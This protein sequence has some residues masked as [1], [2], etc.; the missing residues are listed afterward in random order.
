[1]GEGI[2]TALIC[3]VMSPAAGRSVVS[4][5]T[6]SQSQAALARVPTY[7]VCSPLSN[8][9]RLPLIA[10]RC[11]LS[12][13]RTNGSPAGFYQMTTDERFDRIEEL[14]R[15]LIE[16]RKVK[17]W[18][19]VNEVAE[20]LGKAPFTIREHARLGRISASKRKSGRGPHSE[21]MVSHEEL[22]RIQ[23]EGLLPDPRVLVSVPKTTRWRR[24][25]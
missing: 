12:N 14:L 1:M 13:E 22:I 21:W 8:Y 3:F 4:Q 16:Q 5:T 7:L 17:D 24:S 20:M 9:R 6:N 18:Y 2:L 23:N 10:R 15:T 19:S 11:V 25:R